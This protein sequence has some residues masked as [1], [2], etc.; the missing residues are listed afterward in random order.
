MFG[1]NK[2]ATQN[3]AESTAVSAE[4]DAPRV[5]KGVPTPSRKEQEAARK[6]PLVPND[7]SAAKVADRDARREAQ[8]KTRAALDTGD[9]R[10][11]PLRD[12]GPQKRFARDFI[13]VRTSI[14]EFVMFIAL[15][16]VVLSLF[17]PDATVVSW[18][19]IVF[20]VLVL[21]VVVDSILL[22]RRLKKQLIAKFGSAEAGVVWYG[23]MR[24]L[25]F[26]RLR[27]PKPQVKRGEK[28]G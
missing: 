27:L 12:K 14:G 16:I 25:Q 10:Y 24:S 17:F 11:L 8:L 23:T 13:D 22:G 3:A 4:D 1:R 19:F 5:G 7:R 18:T 15:A 9:E 6:R 26:R 28:L 20:W 2:E 21:A